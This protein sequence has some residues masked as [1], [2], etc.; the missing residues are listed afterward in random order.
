MSDDFANDVKKKLK[1]DAVADLRS[2]LNIVCAIYAEYDQEDDDG[3]GGDD[4]G[5]GGDDG[6]DLMGGDDGFNFA[7]PVKK[8]RDTADPDVD[9]SKFCAPQTGR[10][11]GPRTRARRER[12]GSAAGA[13]RERWR[14]S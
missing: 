13:R 3:D 6:D 4:D 8:T 10:R 12:S 7:E 2:V 5:D 14:R 9:T 11:R 1:K